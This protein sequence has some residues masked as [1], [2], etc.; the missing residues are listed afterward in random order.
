M[1]RKILILFLISVAASIE[2]KPLEW[3]KQ[4]GRWFK[5]IFT[6]PTE[7]EKAPEIEATDIAGNQ[8]F[9]RDYEAK[10]I[11]LSFWASWCPQCKKELPQLDALNI[12]YASK[13]FKFLAIN[14]HDSK[15]DALDYLNKNKYSITFLLDQNDKTSEKYL[16]SPLPTNFLIQK[17]RFRII[18]I[19]EGEFDIKEMETIFEQLLDEKKE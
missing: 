1:R 3:Y 12:K 7:S 5:N 18:K 2:T 9:L 19:W 10:Y 8:K 13:G 6:S 17:D 14:V 4:P 11:L 15:E 16:I